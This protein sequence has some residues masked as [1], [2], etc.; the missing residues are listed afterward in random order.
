VR[1]SAIACSLLIL[2]GFAR[3]ASA[4][5]PPVKPNIIV[6]LV[7]DMGLGDTSAY[8]GK[9]LSPGSAPM[10]LT[11][12]TPNLERLA[13]MGTLFTDVH[14]PSSVC[15]TTRYA[16]LT[17]R[18][19]SRT[20][21]P[22]LVVGSSWTAN[23]MIDAQRETMATMLKRAGYDTMAVGK[24]HLG[25]KTYDLSGNVTTT[26]RNPPLLSDF[27]QVRWPT[28][29]NPNVTGPT[30]A[31]GPNDNGFDYYFGGIHN[32]DPEPQSVRAFFENRNVLGT[33]TWSNGPMATDWD[34]AKVGEIQGNRTLDLIGD[35]IN[36]APE[37]ANPLFMY[38]APHANHSPHVPPVT[39]TIQ[40]TT[41]QVAGQSRYTDGTTGGAAARNRNDLVLQN[42]II[43][44][45]L[46]NKLENSTDPR[47]G[48]RMID[49]TLIIF[50]SDNG[51]DVKTAVSTGGLRDKKRAVTEGGHRVP[52]IAAWP[53]M[54][55]QG[56]VSDQL[57][58]LN[59]LYASFASLTGVS[60]SP[61]EAEDSE[62]IL[63][64]LFGQQNFVRPG[65]AVMHDDSMVNAISEIP[66]GAALAIR[67]GSYKLIVH[68]SLVDAPAQAASISGQAIPVALY[69]LSVDIG[70]TN[71]LVSN[72]AYAG[73]VE[74]LRLQVLKYNNQG[75]SRSTIQHQFGP[76][77]ATDGGTDRNNGYNGS[78]GYEFTVGSAP[79]AITRLGMWDDAA[80]DFAFQ[81]TNNLNPDGDT[82]GIPDGL[83]KPHWIRL[84]DKTTGQQI[85]GLQLT[86]A[87]SVV[88]GEFRYANLNSAVVLH[89]GHQYAL[90]MSTQVGDGDFYHSPLP[91]TGT[92]PI[93]SSL[94]GGFMP[95]LS[96][97]DGAY[98]TLRP[99]G[100]L[101]TGDPTESKYEH[102]LYLGPTATVSQIPLE[103]V[104]FNGDGR[105]DG[106]D[107]LIWQVGFGLAG[108]TR[109]QG[110]ADGNGVVDGRDLNLLLTVASY[111]AS[112]SGSLAGVPE[113]A[114][115][116]VAAAGCMMLG[117]CRKRL[118]KV[119]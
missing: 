115:W 14:S 23:P 71:N 16:L 30:L 95:R 29:S 78:L 48:G 104:D 75:F 27:E 59:D 55:P 69:D 12:R 44:G 41:Y 8:L 46:L 88:E 28:V 31:F 80:D 107:F 5:A 86:N 11:T 61:Y 54:I 4:Q 67:S 116:T 18:Y 15:S 56:A 66:D 77:F 60:L 25:V 53:G 110:D 101:P 51:A 106:G 72:P 102:T 113:P 89:A 119:V 40:G 24:W 99:G 43:L 92:T 73:V 103:F 68:P 85:A 105:A 79:V 33:L 7:D 3:P 65:Y 64:A 63:P 36:T 52:F 1:Q 118:R 42:D 26:I 93:P 19:A 45:E 32:N 94:V 58:G 82:V 111:Q 117:V 100:V 37:S 97:S 96:P 112:L 83:A 108:A 109:Q 20:N 90:T 47:T 91:N 114:S 38:Y 49:N 87:N 70:E 98:P 35:Y 17:G 84:F 74:Q 21:V 81:E 2:I 22:H 9:Q 39:M 62:N 34:A 50:T 57:F 6:M 13:S 10:A 76:M